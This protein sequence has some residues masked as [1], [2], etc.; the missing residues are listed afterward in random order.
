MELKHIVGI[1]LGG[2]AIYGGYKL[3]QRNTAA[4]STGNGGTTTG[5]KTQD[6]SCLGDVYADG[7]TISQEL[8][9]KLKA[10]VA[11][12]V[13]PGIAYDMS[14]QAQS[15]AFEAALYVWSTQPDISR[16]EKIRIV[17]S[18]FIAPSCDWSSPLPYAYDQPQSKVWRGVGLIVDLAS[19]NLQVA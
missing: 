9:D 19:A 16:D 3:Y 18:Q 8:M 13:E 7:A 4:P 17:V 6:V 15:D 12:A 11:A 1:A 14:A 10:P 5:T 2:A